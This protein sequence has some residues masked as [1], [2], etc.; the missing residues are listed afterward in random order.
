M[1]VVFTPI[2]QE[3][4]EPAAVENN[5]RSF[6]RR[7][8]GIIP[9]C[10][11]IFVFVLATVLW[12]SFDN[13]VPIW[14]SANHL[15]HSYELSEIFASDADISSKVH[16]AITSSYYY[17]PF[18][19]L[20]LT[21]VRGLAGFDSPLLDE[22]PCLLFFALA[23]FSLYKLGCLLLNDSKAALAGSF[24][25]CCLPA[26]TRAIHP[27]AL[28]DLPVTAMVFI[29][30]YFLV[31]WYK[32]PSWM[33]SVAIGVAIGL[34]ALTKQYGVF[35]FVPPVMAFFVVSL[36]NREYKKLLML[37]SQGLI[38]LA[39]V[40]CWLIPN[41]P[42]LTTFMSSN[43]LSAEEGN[44]FLMWWN[45]VVQ[46]ALLAPENITFPGLFI[47]FLSFSL[48]G[49]H[50]K[51]WIL[52]ISS[53]FC[54]VLICTLNWDPY[55]FRYVIPVVGYI[56]LAVGALISTL[57]FNTSNKLFQAGGVL[58]IS[59]YLF[60]F[61]Y[62]NYAPY[63]L[64]LKSFQKQ[65][66]RFDKLVGFDR[67]KKSAKYTEPLSPLPFTDWGREWV[68]STILKHQTEDWS[69]VCVLPDTFEHSTLTYQYLARSAGKNIT[70]QTLRNWSTRGYD[71]QYSDKDLDSFN[72]FLA[73]ENQ[74]SRP[75]AVFSS[76][77]AQKNY[78]A[79]EELLRSS[80]RFRAVDERSMPDGSKVILYRNLSKN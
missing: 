69:Y 59:W 17:P 26:I 36:K 29:S 2:V 43:H 38:A 72:W 39:I 50:K 68:I 45:N 22:I 18:F 12:K 31:R 5:S 28:L 24:V 10:L 37:F 51:L 49:V 4:N 60:S 25:F 3:C 13:H 27:K 77:K 16:R 76:S 23:T 15:L 30:F 52:S 54:W 80:D 34:T 56:S 42:Q 11:L 46:I 70:F 63:P 9:V 78:E 48:P 41:L 71:F 32:T 61:L 58:I 79:L 53:L 67:A 44:F 6:L 55:Q 14:D 33:W 73:L 8:A 64:S 35:Y 62:L 21:A 65:F 66:D 19:Y 7:I 74:K 20:C 47:F 1:I 57:L 75:G 40:L